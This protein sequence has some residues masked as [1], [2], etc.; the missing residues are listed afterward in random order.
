LPTSRGYTPSVFS[1]LTRLLERGGVQGSGGS[2][3]ALY[4]VFVDGDDLTDPIADAVRAILDGHIVLSRTLAQRGVFPAVDVIQSVSRLMPEVVRPDD[5][6]TAGEVV[7]V[8]ATYRS[9]Q[10]LIEVGAYRAGA[11]DEID[12]AIRL[13]PKLEKF[14]SQTVQDV[15]SRSAAL[16]RLRALL[17]ARSTP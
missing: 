6:V 11:N 2:L 8:L 1:L 9:S 17:A 3:T 7:K 16:E 13:L 4:T 14:L 5:L 15:E 12:R 10:D